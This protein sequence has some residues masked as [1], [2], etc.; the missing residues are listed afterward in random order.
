MNACKRC[1]G[2]GKVRHHRKVYP[3]F[4]RC[5]ETPKEKLKDL[6]SVIGTHAVR[7]LQTTGLLNIWRNSSPHN[8]WVEAKRKS[9]VW[10]SGDEDRRRPNLEM[11]DL[12]SEKGRVIQYWGSD[13]GRPMHSIYRL[14]GR[15]RN[16]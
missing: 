10:H 13:S 15:Y 16:A 2:T 8:W 7:S 12:V 1:N 3:C 5:W 9:T 4:S 14:K 11:F 6:R